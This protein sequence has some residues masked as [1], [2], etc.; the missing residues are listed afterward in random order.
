LIVWL[1]FS[2][3]YNNE[4]QGKETQPSFFMYRDHDKP[5]HIDYC[6]CNKDLIKKY[7]I[8]LAR[9]WLE[10]SDHMPIILDLAL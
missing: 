5:Y 7:D 1:F 3:D 2:D 9:K 6:F 10:L 4:E 8:G